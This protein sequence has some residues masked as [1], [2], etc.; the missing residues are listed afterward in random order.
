MKSKALWVKRIRADIG[1]ERM[2]SDGGGKV[3]IKRQ[4]CAIDSFINICK[5][6]ELSEG[7]THKSSDFH[8]YRKDFY[9]RYVD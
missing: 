9:S 4:R 7:M 3:T 1:N 2:R 8:G 5:K 6:K